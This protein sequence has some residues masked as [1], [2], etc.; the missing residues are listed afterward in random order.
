MRSVIRARGG[1]RLNIHCPP[2]EAS[3]LAD[4]PPDV[5]D[6]VA[7]GSRCLLARRPRAAVVMY[8]GA[9]AAMIS[10]L[11]D[12]SR[13]RFRRTADILDESPTGRRPT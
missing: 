7:E 4:V 9:L 12:G 13:Q 3:H 10:G 6:L 11:S 8:R 2:P 1:L 5:A